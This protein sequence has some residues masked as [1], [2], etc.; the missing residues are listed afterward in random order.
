MA[1]V[2]SCT[3]HKG[4]CYIDGKCHSSEDC[5]HKAKTNGDMIRSMSDRELY[6]FL[7]DIA[8]DGPWDIKFERAFCDNC[9][10]IRIEKN[11]FGREFG[12]YECEDGH[13]P[14]YDGNALKWWLEEVIEWNW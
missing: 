11:L 4:S 8:H 2:Y 10:P 6:E 13:C 5:M 3:C 1:N 7:R 14:H 12:R 9:I